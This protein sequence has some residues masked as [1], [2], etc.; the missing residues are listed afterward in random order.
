MEKRK[1]PR[2]FSSPLFLVLATAISLILWVIPFGWL[3]LYPFRIFATF[4]H[5]GGHALIAILTMGAVDRIVI[6]ADASGETYT[7]GGSA[8]LI[9]SAGYLVSC[10]FGAVLLAL[11]RR[12]R[13]AA[14][15]LFVNSVLTLALTFY[16]L[17]DQ[18]S[19]AAGLALSV[20]LLLAGMTRS[21]LCHL[22]L[23]LLAVQCCLN[24]VFD[25]LTL[26]RVTTGA[27]QLHNDA[28]IMERL[29]FITAPVWAI[30]WAGISLIFL[31]AGLLIYAR[32]G[33]R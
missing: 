26:L 25:L 14:V 1:T 24:A 29:T 32:A 28:M 21:A 17:R 5:E 31:T 16:F 13:N 15:M 4:V 6:Y 3:V 12:G 10:G 23:N 7:R 30:L 27:V 8:L 2:D 20:C 19:L 11:S 9:A 33:H 18:L 22:L